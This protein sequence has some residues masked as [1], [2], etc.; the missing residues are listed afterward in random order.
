[1]VDNKIKDTCKMINR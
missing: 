1:M